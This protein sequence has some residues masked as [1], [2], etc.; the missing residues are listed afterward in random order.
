MRINLGTP[1]LHGKKN[2]ATNKPNVNVSVNAIC[3]LP[4]QYRLGLPKIIRHNKN[5]CQAPFLFFLIFLPMHLLDPPSHTFK[6]PSVVLSPMCDREGNGHYT[7]SLITPVGKIEQLR[8][9]RDREGSFL[10]EVFARYH[11]AG[12]WSQIPR[13][14]NPIGPPSPHS[15]KILRGLPSFKT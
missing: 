3:H 2:Y 12:G 10:T 13:P 8:G 1:K 15:F 11:L 6:R 7:R 4:L 5:C 14:T 9:P